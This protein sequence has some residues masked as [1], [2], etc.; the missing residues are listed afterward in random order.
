L[1]PS[2]SWTVACWV[3]EKTG[4]CRTATRPPTPKSTRSE[5]RA[6]TR[7]PFIAGS[8]HLHELRALPDVPRRHLVGKD[9]SHRVRQQPRRCFRYR[10]R[11]CR[12]LWRGKR[13]ARKSKNQDRAKRR[14]RREGSIC[15]MGPK[16]RQSTVLIVGWA[17]RKRAQHLG[18][19][20]GDGGH[21]ARAPL[22][23]LRLPL[24]T[25]PPARSCR[26]IC[27]IPA[28]RGHA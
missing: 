26:V 27:R 5:M 1:E 9:I 24:A 25:T 15:G 18:C 6:G 17:K 14:C 12:T 23:T 13:A 7:R 20:P 10:L 2:S 28:R 11:R 4:W 8:C 21:G 3:K 16:R 19:D 22:P